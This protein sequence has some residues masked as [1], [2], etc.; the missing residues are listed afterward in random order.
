MGEKDTEDSYAESWLHIQRKASEAFTLDF[1]GVSAS[2]GFDASL[3]LKAL[4]IASR[5]CAVVGLTDAAEVIDRAK[6]YVS[7]LSGKP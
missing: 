3:R 7:F 5:E 2:T 1:P 4:E 6:V